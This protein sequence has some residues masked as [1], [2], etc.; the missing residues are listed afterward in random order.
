MAGQRPEG[1]PPY[2]WFIAALV[3]TVMLLVL[4]IWTGKTGRRRAHV[5]LVGITIPSLATA[6]LLAERVG[7]YWTLPRVPLTIHLVFAYGASVGALVATAS[8]V[9]HLFGRV[10][11]RRHARLA[12]LF[13]VTATLAVV[14]GIVMFLGGTPKV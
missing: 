12:W 4:D 7:T 1:H 11:R 3:V 8:G 6:V 9:L 5:V 10:P 13:V 14:T 2:A